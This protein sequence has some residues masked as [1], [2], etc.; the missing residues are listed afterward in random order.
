MVDLPG[1]DVAGAHARARRPCAA[2][3]DAVEVDR[4]RVLRPVHEPDPQPLALAGAQRRPRHAAVVGPGGVLH[5]RAPPRSP[6]PR[7]PAP[8]RARRR[9]RAPSSKSRRISCGSKPFARGSTL[10]TAPE[11]GRAACA[12]ACRRAMCGSAA[13]ASDRVQAA[14]RDQLVQ[15]GQRR[16]PPPRRPAAAAEKVCLATIVVSSD[17]AAPKSITRDVIATSDY[18]LVT[19]SVGLVDRSDR[20][21][22]LVRGAEA[23]DFLQGQVSNDVEA[24]EPGQRLLRHGPQPQGQAAHRPAHPARRRLVLARHRGHRPRG[25]RAHA[26]GPTRSAATS[27]SRT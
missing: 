17:L 16:R 15:H 25:A 22:F 6:S 1:L 14:V 18:E 27:S 8:T 19:E 11:V 2:R 26:A 23:A 24:L 7:R 12:P 20:A 3:V 13:D 9:P 5:A 10:P 4:V 21:K